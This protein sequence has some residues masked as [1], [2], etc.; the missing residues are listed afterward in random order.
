[1]ANMVDLTR[2]LDS[3]LQAAK[4]DLIHPSTHPHRSRMLMSAPEYM[5]KSSDNSWPS[6][7]ARWIEH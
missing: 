2:I 3:W 5:R 6:A 4:V 7:A 1:M